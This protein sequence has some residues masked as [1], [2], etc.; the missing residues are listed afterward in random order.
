MIPAA[1]IERVEALLAGDPGIVQTPDDEVEALLAPSQ[2]IAAQTWQR[3]LMRNHELVLHATDP[4]PSW[5]ATR[6]SS[7]L[8]IGSPGERYSVSLVKLDD[9]GHELG[10][11]D[12]SK[13]RLELRVQRNETTSDYI[14][15]EF[16]ADYLAWDESVPGRL[17]IHIPADL[18]RG[19]LLIGVRPALE[20]AGENALAERW[21][22][23]IL[24]DVWPLKIG[25]TPV[26]EADVYFPLGAD[27]HTR[28][29]CAF[30][31]ATITDT[32]TQAAAEA[33]EP[34]KALVVKGRHL[35]AQTL[36]DYRLPETDGGIYPYGGRIVEVIEGSDDQLLLLVNFEVLSV[37]DILSGSDNQFIEEGVL[38]EFVTYRTGPALAPDDE[39]GE[40]PMTH[41]GPDDRATIQGKFSLFD[42]ECEYGS[43]PTIA[44]T[45]YFKL[46]ADK[47]V[48]A[49]LKLSLGIGLGAVE[50]E[51]KVEC[52]VKALEGADV[53]V[54]LGGPMGV[55][56]QKLIGTG[57]SVG[58]YGE[59]KVRLSVGGG[60]TNFMLTGGYSVTQGPIPPILKWDGSM[61]SGLEA[62]PI[63]A[64]VYLGGELGMKGKLAAADVQI[65]KLGTYDIS[66]T[67]TLGWVA[68]LSGAAFNAASVKAG[69]NSVLAAEFGAKFETKISAGLTNMLKW[70]GLKADFDFE[71]KNTIIKKVDAVYRL[72]NLND[73]GKGQASVVVKPN[74]ILA[75]F[76]LS[77]FAHGYAS[78]DDS[79]VY[80][81]PNS[82]ITYDLAECAATPGGHIVTPVV[83]VSQ[84]TSCSQ[85]VPWRPSPPILKYCRKKTKAST[86]LL[87]ARRGGCSGGRSPQTPVTA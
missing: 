71:F 67:S 35:E 56:L 41:Y 59:L 70:L 52:I 38:P 8:L 83:G 66:L 86:P 81:D 5:V 44:V 36:I 79:S 48:D 24:I 49:G 16:Q 58:P 72:F 12:S 27:R 26:E 42:T 28:D 31:D 32:L 37:Y 65:P 2:T 82:D 76:F 77:N 53:P 68:G 45:P 54:P 19:R 64:K 80:N 22:V 40:P 30:D 21:S 84:W 3:H 75:E 85:E 23:P 29:G 39:A 11:V 46:D 60:F 87:P 10:P 15:T 18:A 43:T 61:G 9:E 74:G 62:N 20:S 69:N 47:G 6:A 50:K 51:T 73:D 34:L 17:N 57:V 78:L 33:G 4:E 7:T 25:V 63:A 14:P 55:V 13:L 1:M